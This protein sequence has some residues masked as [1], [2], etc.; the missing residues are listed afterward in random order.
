MG[1]AK[2]SGGWCEPGGRN[3]LKR[4]SEKPPERSVGLVGRRRYRFKLARN[5]QSEWYRGKSR[6]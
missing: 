2:A 1:K 5:G 6:L 3:I 4:I